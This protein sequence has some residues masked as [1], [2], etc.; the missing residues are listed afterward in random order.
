[1]GIA[2]D[3]PGFLESGVE[4]LGDGIHTKSLLAL[5]K[6][7]KVSFACAGSGA[8]EATVRSKGTTEVKKLECDGVPVPTRVQDAP[9][10]ITIDVTALAKASG[11][12][13]YRIAEFTP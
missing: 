10:R 11:M 7:Y 5:G 6:S 1:M 13:A 12:V 2:S 4:R 9:S 3:E 8:A